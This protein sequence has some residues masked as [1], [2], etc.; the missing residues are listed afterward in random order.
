MNELLLVTAGCLGMTIAV[1]H[2]YLGEMKVVRPIQGLGVSTKRVARA[3]WFLSAVYW[4]AG[5]VILAASPWY[6]ARE[7]Y[8][9]LALCVG[10]MYLAG[11]AANFWA[12]RGR[13]FGWVLLSA[14]AGLIWFGA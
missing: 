6:S 5:G 9:V 10:A 8:P 11:A 3:I 13:H 1:V 4:F 12:T 2:G 7:G 14:T